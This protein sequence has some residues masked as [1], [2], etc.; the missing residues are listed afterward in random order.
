MKIIAALVYLAVMGVY[1]HVLW[2]EDI[3]VSEPAAWGVLAF[4]AAV[5]VAAGLTIGLWAVLLPFAAVLVAVPAG[6]GGSGPGGAHLVLLRIHHVD[7]R[8]G[9]GRSRHRREVAAEPR[10]LE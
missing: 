5:H 6:Y 7:S 10:A 4:L 1:F 8:R 9:S 2:K 3:W